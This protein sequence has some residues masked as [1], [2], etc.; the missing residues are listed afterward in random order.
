MTLNPW[1]TIHAGVDLPGDNFIAMSITHQKTPASEAITLRIRRIGAHF[2]VTKGAN[3][4]G[5]PAD[6]ILAIWSAVFAAE[7]IAKG[8]KNVRVVTVRDRRDIERFFSRA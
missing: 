1:R 8:R 4:L 5:T 6:E 7:E 2:E 3:P